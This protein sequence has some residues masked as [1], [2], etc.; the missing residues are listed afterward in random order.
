MR[1]TLPSHGRDR[2]ALVGGSARRAADPVEPLRGRSGWD[3]ATLE[4]LVDHH[5]PTLHPEVVLDG[6]R[7]LANKDAIAIDVDN[8]AV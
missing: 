5:L 7:L 6:W 1:V 4:R 8:G 2:L 3:H